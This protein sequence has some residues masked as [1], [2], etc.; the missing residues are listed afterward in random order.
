MVLLAQFVAGNLSVVFDVD[1]TATTR[2]ILT[3]VI[4][5]VL[6]ITIDWN[7][8]HEIILWWCC[9]YI[10]YACSLYTQP[11]IIQGSRKRLICV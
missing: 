6:C 8:D 7:L 10:Y 11:S 1:I 3:E 5:C 4:S 2:N 9:K